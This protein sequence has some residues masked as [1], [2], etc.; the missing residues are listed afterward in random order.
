MRLNRLLGVEKDGP[1]YDGARACGEEGPRMDILFYFS[2]DSLGGCESYGTHIRRV[3]VCGFWTY[4]TA[5]GGG[6]K[7]G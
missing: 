5:V 6:G 7:T 2:M 4:W 1:G 3:S